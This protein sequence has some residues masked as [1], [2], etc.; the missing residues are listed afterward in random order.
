MGEGDNGNISTTEVDK[1]DFLP[2]AHELLW[3]GRMVPLRS[4]HGIRPGLTCLRVM[5]VR[6]NSLHVT[7]QLS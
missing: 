4:P 5:M 1:K 2:T 3:P 6:W 7:A